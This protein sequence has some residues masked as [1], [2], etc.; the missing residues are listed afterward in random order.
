MSILRHYIHY[1]IYVT[2]ATVAV[3]LSSCSEQDISYD[4]TSMSEEHSCQS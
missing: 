3:V 1:L 4:F 2:V